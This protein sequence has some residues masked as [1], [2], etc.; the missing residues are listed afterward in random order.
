MP[1]YHYR[2]PVTG[3]PT[4]PGPDRG[5]P[6]AATAAA[7][8]VAVRGAAAPA[9][10]L[11]LARRAEADVARVKDYHEIENLESA[12]GYYLDKNLWD[13][14]ADLFAR[15]GSMELAQRGVYKGA[16]V[17]DFLWKVFGRGG[18]RDRSPG[19]WAT[20]CNCSPSSGGA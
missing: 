14:L 5:G 17:R 4:Y 8:A 3:S 13:P 10:N 1:P 11:S 19:A 6:S 7:G 15:N 12:Y 9:G 16:R 20:I 18:S 2:N